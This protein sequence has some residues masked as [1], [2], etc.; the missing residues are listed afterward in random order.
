[1]VMVE[2]SRFGLFGDLDLDEQVWIVCAGALFPRLAGR[3]V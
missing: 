3:I 1:M 2:V